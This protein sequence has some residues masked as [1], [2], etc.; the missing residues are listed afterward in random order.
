M[1]SK[2]NQ[3][4]IN[5]ISDGYSNIET[6]KDA[7]VCYC[8]ENITA[9]M[10]KCTNCEKLFHGDCLKNGRPSNFK[11]DVFFDFTCADCSE[12]GKEIFKRKPMN[13]LQV[14]YLALYNLICRGSGRKGYFRWRDDLCQFIEQNWNCFHAEKKKTMS[15]CSTVAGTL[16]S[17]CPKIFK[18]GQKEFK[19]GGW[20]SLNEVLPPSEK[21]EVMMQGPNH[22]RKKKRSSIGGVK[23]SKKSKTEAKVD[24]NGDADVN[25][26]VF[27][28]GNTVS[29][30]GMDTNDAMISIMDEANID[31][32]LD[33]NGDMSD[34]DI[35]DP[36]AMDEIFRSLDL[37]R[38]DDSLNTSF[39]ESKMER[40]EDT[41]T[42]L[43]QVEQPT[44]IDSTENDV[45]V[46]DPNEVHGT[47]SSAFTIENDHVEKSTGHRDK[48]RKKNLRTMYPHEEKDL[49]EKLNQ[50]DSSDVRARRLRRKLLLNRQ[51]R[52]YGLPV[53]DLD[54][55][56]ENSM[57]TVSHYIVDKGEC[58][59][60]LKQPE[61][62]T[63]SV[64]G[65]SMQRI[66]LRRDRILDRFMMQPVSQRLIKP[67]SFLSRLIGCHPS[68]LNRSITS[69][70]TSRVLKPFIRRDFEAEPTKL[71][72]LKEI[73]M[74][75]Q[76][77][78]QGEAHAHD[79]CT[80]GSIDYC[81]VQ[82]HHIP[83]VNAL[84]REFFWCGIDLSECLQY[85]D[86]TCIVLYKKLIIGCAFMVPDVKCNE[87]YISFVVVHPDWRRAGIGSFMIYHLIQT[88]LGKDVTLHVAADNPAM[89][90]YQKFGFKPER[91]VA[92]FY[93]RY[94][95]THSEHSK[96]AFF[97]RLQ[98]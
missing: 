34:L 25:H 57:N 71:K 59:A 67:V 5:T 58:T 62:H 89:L 72:V 18:N 26:D 82:P 15:W 30:N 38:S 68:A 45:I 80:F 21:P 20:W 16:S 28:Y 49:L 2:A 4:N 86:F 81:Y 24:V 33:C 11:G 27:D 63:D 66:A 29:T 88:C 39:T 44:P 73:T 41:G 31:T 32:F 77:K 52:Q 47:Q 35:G 61:V 14:V 46:L 70:Y 96:H 1:A 54:K 60:V 79:T 12:T 83:G 95:P 69:P 87:A 23:G 7:V 48:S 55:F 91:F 6:S 10:L 51:K 74:R 85:P 53:F 50:I 22:K 84:C 64:R 13:W 97:L 36:G 92:G 56:I 42:K 90:L 76:K 75:F 17:N 9:S 94:F 93:D 43:E 65:T 37:N 19:E 98:R 3:K 40:E 8:G 78:F